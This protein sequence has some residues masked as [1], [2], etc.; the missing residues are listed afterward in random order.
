MKEI[1]AEGMRYIYF[2]RDDGLT[3]EILQQESIDG[4]SLRKI[5]DEVLA[6]S[7]DD[8]RMVLIPSSMLPNMLYLYFLHWSDKK[9][10]DLLDQKVNDGTYTDDDFRNSVVTNFIRLKCVRNAD[11]EGDAL[12]LRTSDAYL[13]VR[14]LEEKKID[15]LWHTNG[16]LMVCPNCGSNLHQFVV[17]IFEEKK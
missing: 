5:W 15:I 13:H 14:G 9:D 7:L 11:W 3:T 12:V 6:N 17:K 4:P 16:A 10:L 8:I 1:Q 2:T